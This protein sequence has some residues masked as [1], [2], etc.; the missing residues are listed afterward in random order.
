MLDVR[1]CQQLAPL[2]AVHRQLEKVMAGLARDFVCPGV[3]FTR[4]QNVDLERICTLFHR[5]STPGPCLHL[6][7]ERIPCGLCQGIPLVL[8]GLVEPCQANEEGKVGVLRRGVV[9][10]RVDVP[11]RR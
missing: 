1:R 2:L 4:F 6:F 7:L 9:C 3:V 10:V 8:G 11:D 5:G